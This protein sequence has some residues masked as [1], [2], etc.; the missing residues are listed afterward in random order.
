LGSGGCIFSIIAGGCISDLYERKELL[1]LMSIAYG[2]SCML[3]AAAPN[4][5]LLAI[6]AVIVNLCWAGDLAF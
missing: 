6:A 5:Q 3:L 1:E 4:W 2:M